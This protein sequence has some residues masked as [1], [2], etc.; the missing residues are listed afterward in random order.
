MLI[1][2]GL[3]IVGVFVSLLIGEIE[4]KLKDIPAILDNKTGMDYMILSKIRIPRTLLA[5]S[6]GGA[7]S[8]LSIFPMSALLFL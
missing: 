5:I 8:I 6:V 7:L 3:L 1:L 4:I 2:F